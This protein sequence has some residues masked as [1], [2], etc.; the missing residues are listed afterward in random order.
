MQT[1]FSMCVCIHYFVKLCPKFAVYETSLSFISLS[2]RM[3]STMVRRKVRR[4]AMGELSCIPKMPSLGASKN[5]IGIRKSPCLASARVLAYRAFPMVCIIMLFK[6]IHPK[7]GKVR[8]L[9]L[10]ERVP[11]S[12]TSASSFLNNAKISGA[13]MK[14]AKERTHKTIVEYFTQKKNAFFTRSY[15]F[16]P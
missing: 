6:V 14:P 13:K 4:S 3:P 5:K 9:N 12:I 2:T 16:A 8:Q 11:I 15:R 10:R 7:S 1:H